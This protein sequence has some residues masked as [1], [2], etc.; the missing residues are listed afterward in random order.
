MEKVSFLVLPFLATAP[1]EGFSPNVLQKVS[2]M[3]GMAV[4]DALLC[5]RLGH[6][7][8]PR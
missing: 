7:G 6:S 5:K 2:E 8:E 4:S 3:L 1:L